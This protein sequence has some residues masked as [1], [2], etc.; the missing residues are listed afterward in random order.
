MN[1]SNRSWS[2]D[3]S[4]VDF[5]KVSLVTDFILEV[6]KKRS[7]KVGRGSKEEESEEVESVAE[8]ARISI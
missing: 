8:A 2:S 4:N 5:W 6:S 1:R 3:G 7:L